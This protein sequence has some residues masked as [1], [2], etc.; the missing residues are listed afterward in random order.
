MDVAGNL[1]SN[2]S[3]VCRRW[4]ADRTYRERGGVTAASRTP[5]GLFQ[6]GD[7]GTDGVEER[8]SIFVKSHETCCQ[9]KLLI[10]AT[11]GLI[12]PFAS[13]NVSVPVP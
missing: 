6:D 2:V 9:R 4:L 3:S 5:L 13:S 10:S 12:S 8:T 11:S 7:V 1:V